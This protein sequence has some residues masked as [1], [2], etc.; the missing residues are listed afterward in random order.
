MPTSK[1]VFFKSVVVFYLRNLVILLQDKCQ[2]IQIL[3]TT[4]TDTITPTIDKY[5]QAKNELN[6]FAITPSKLP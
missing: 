4:I 6:S 3:S 5:K 1:L 2:R